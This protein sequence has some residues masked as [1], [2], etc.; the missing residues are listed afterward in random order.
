MIKHPRP[1]KKRINRPGRAASIRLQR[2]G[3]LARLKAIYGIE[4]AHVLGVSLVDPSQIIRVLVRFKDKC[5]SPHSI[6][7]FR[8]MLTQILQQPTVVT[9]MKPEHRMERGWVDL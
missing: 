4:E 8:S 2:S 3:D 6:E 5:A 7:M 1:S 9:E